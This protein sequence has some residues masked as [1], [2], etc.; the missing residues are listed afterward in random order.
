MQLLSD[1]LLNNKH[2]YSLS[3]DQLLQKR[4]N[5]FKDQ[6]LSANLYYSS[7][8][9]EI[10][11]LAIS[12][13]DLNRVIFNI[14]AFIKHHNNR[15]KIEVKNNSRFLSFSFSCI[16]SRFPSQQKGFFLLSPQRSKNARQKSY[17]NSV[18]T[19]VSES[20]GQLSYSKTSPS[21][22]RLDLRIPLS[23]QIN[24][25]NRYPDGYSDHRVC[26]RKAPSK[27]GVFFNRYFGRL[28]VL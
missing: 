18:S 17:L 23:S 28:E 24:E 22:W 20:G 19:L 7:K 27:E 10:N 11:E 8:V 26:L 2:L 1:I 15:L 12:E 5:Y 21:E 6:G 3:I 16:G 4:L 9:K 25:F 14:L 13:C